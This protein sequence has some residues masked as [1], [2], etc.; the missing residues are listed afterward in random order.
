MAKLN[1]KYLEVIGKIFRSFPEFKGKER[2][3]R[4]L[5]SKSLN[6]NLD[7]EVSGK[8]DCRYILPNI[9]ENIGNF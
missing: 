7:I 2:L 5:L 9:K 8:F 6:K 4:M 3:A 1:L